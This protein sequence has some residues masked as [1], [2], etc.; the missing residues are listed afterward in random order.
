MR[1]LFIV[2]VL[3]AAAAGGAYVVAGRGAP[4]VI[5]IDKP[6]RLVGQTGTLE[7]TVE[8][9]N[10]QLSL[11]TIALE[12]NGRTTPLFA[13][14]AEQGATVT[15]VD[16]NHLRIS[17]PFGKTAVPALQAGTARL[18][19][20]AARPSLLKLKTLSSQATRDV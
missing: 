10:A 9:P 15:R 13:L 18:S 8:A 16:A 11:L 19:V 12:Q 4:P 7:V 17:R 6:E 20:A 14:D 1:W 5:A 3:V 2:L